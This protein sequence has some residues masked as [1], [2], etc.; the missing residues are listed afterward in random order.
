MHS[1]PVRLLD[2]SLMPGT[3]LDNN[4]KPFC[5]TMKCHRIMGAGDFC[6][7]WYYRA[8]LRDY[9][10]SWHSV[11][12]TALNN[13]LTVVMWSCLLASLLH[14]HKSC[15]IHWN[16]YVPGEICLIWIAPSEWEKFSP[17]SSVFLNMYYCV[18]MSSIEDNVH[19]ECCVVIS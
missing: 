13:M 14:G 3:S 7:I 16:T 15:V 17:S 6:M 1:C 8:A 18:L 4:C 11:H 2:L 10:T 19:K 9:F 5:V 12:Q